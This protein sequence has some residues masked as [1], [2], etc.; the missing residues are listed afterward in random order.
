MRGNYSKSADSHSNVVETD[1]KRITKDEE[2]EWT[3]KEA[4][5]VKKERMRSL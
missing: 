4:K 3:W 2:E 5:G 1:A